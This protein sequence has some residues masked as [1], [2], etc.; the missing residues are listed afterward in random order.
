MDL[1]VCEK[2]ISVT[3]IVNGTTRLQP[4]VMLTG[5][6]AGVLAALSSKIEKESEGSAG[7]NGTGGI[8]ESKSVPD[9][10]CGCETG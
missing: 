6:G 7:K 1:I 9:A 4:V 8:T 5:Q 10:F 2:G 3:N